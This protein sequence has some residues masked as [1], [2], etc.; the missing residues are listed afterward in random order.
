[1]SGPS[2]AWFDSKKKVVHAS[3]QQTGR[4]QLERWLF[5]RIQRTL[6]LDKLVFFDE[7]GVNLSMA[8][9]YGRSIRGQRVV[10]YVPKDWGGNVTLIAG[11]RLSGI[12]SPMML[13]GSLT[14]E[15]MDLYVS[16]CVVPEL[17]EGD[18]VVFD[19]LNIH[20]RLSVR[21]SLESVGAELLF[22]PAYSPDL[23]PIELA[24]SKLKSVLRSRAARTLE[25][26][27]K[28]VADAFFAITLD[29]IKNWIKHC[30]Y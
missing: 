16:E 4:I 8:R 25:E 13:E 26:L 3:E 10:G 2:K 21:R 15:F 14:G 7:S 6:P 28:A 27:E 9:F 23:N 19:N 17:T 22:L 11:I 18:I 24:W 1:L 5:S 12:V 29:D 30:G 20:K